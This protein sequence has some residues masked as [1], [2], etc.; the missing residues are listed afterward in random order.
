M[1]VVGGVFVVGWW[2][3]LESV[4]VCWSVYFEEI[5]VWYEEYVGLLDFESYW[6]EVLE[7]DENVGK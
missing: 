1:V 4:K 7:D 5:V 6:F 3:W 2:F